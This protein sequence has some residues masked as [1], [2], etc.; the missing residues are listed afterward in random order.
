MSQINRLGFGFHYY[1]LYLAFPQQDQGGGGAGGREQTERTV[2]SLSDLPPYTS[3]H[4]I[5]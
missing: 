3:Y 4:Y 5:L 1:S 2:T